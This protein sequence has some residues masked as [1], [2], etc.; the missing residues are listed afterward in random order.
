MPESEGLAQHG[1]SRMDNVKSALERTS[2]YLFTPVLLTN[3]V[4]SCRW[5]YN[6]KLKLHRFYKRRPS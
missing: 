4:C 2:L 5:P 3:T 1:A 6:S